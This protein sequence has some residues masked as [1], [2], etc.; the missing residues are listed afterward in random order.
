V[1]S[2]RLQARQEEVRKVCQKCFEEH[3][4]KKIQLQRYA[5][6]FIMIEKEDGQLEA[7]VCEIN[8]LG[9]F[10]GFGM[11]SW[12]LEADRHVILGSDFEFR[13]AVEEPKVLDM[14]PDYQKLLDKW[15]ELVA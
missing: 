9:E 8:P 4:T 6:D 5:I 13:V 10:T 15:E 1:V 3:L 11:F 12:E 2:K 7:M 14:S